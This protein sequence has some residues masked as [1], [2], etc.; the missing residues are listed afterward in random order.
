MGSAC[1]LPSLKLGWI[2]YWNLLPLRTEL[3]K[4]GPKN[5][6]FMSGHPTQVNRWLSEGAVDAAPS[7]SICLLRN[8]G[9][10]LAL[11]LGVASDGPVH[12]VYLGVTGA[13]SQALTERIARRMGSLRE[14]VGYATSRHPRDTRLA[15][16]QIWKSARDLRS[17]SLVVPQLKLSAASATSVMLSKIMY[18]LWFGDEAYA[19]M[20]QRDGALDS[21]SS[22]GLEL[23]IGDEALVRRSEFDHIIDLGAQWKALTQLPF[24]FAIWQTKS[25]GLPTIWKK[26]IG[27][28]AA[29]A[30]A[31]MRV[32]PCSYY[33]DQM[34][35]AKDGTPV[36]LAGYW[37]AIQYRLS[38]DHMRGLL[39]YLCLA[40]PLLSAE[41]DEESVIKM[42]RWQ[43]LG[44]EQDAYS[45]D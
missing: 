6:E 9:H 10:D 21:K 34:P 19:A 38:P 8:G 12:S 30:Q 26:K 7:S 32:Q 35:S 45:A 13:D 14:V 18:R 16:D 31:Q 5:V 15:A 27:D 28:A 22:V 4:L 42:L 33:P 3:Q 44:R 43:D 23:V 40:R 11:P 41:V 39:L 2:P 24:V 37:K 20:G 1:S 17:A 29:L 25:K 36:D